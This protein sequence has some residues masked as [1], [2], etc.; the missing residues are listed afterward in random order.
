ML[1]HCRFPFARIYLDRLRGRTTETDI[2]LEIIV[3]A[4]EAFQGDTA[5]VDFYQQTINRIKQQ[6]PYRVALAKQILL[7]LAHARRRLT[8]TELQHVLFAKSL[9]RAISSPDLLDEDELLAMCAGLVTIEQNRNIVQLVHPTLREYLKSRSSDLLP[10]TEQDIARSCLD[11]L[12]LNRFPRRNFTQLQELEEWLASHPFYDYAATNWGHHARESSLPNEGLMNF[13]DD[14]SAVENSITVLMVGGSSR[15][16]T[17]FAD[18]PK[19][20]SVTS[21][22]LATYFQLT[23][24]VL[25]LLRAG[26][27]PDSRDSQGRTPLS[28]TA[29]FGYEAIVSL[30]LEA[31]AE[32]DSKGL[33]EHA[34]TGESSWPP[35]NNGGHA[36]RTPLSF[37]AEYGHVEASK[38]LISHGAD[39]GS[40]CSKHDYRGWTPLL[41]AVYHGHKDVVALLLRCNA[42]LEQP[43]MNDEDFGKTALSH[44][45]EKGH[46]AIVRMLL[47][48]GAS[49][50]P[51]MISTHP[52]TVGHTPLWLAAFGG[53]EAVVELLLEIGGVPLG[54]RDKFG[55][56]IL[57]YMAER[58]HKAMVGFI[59]NYWTVNHQDNN[60]RTPLSYA[61]EAGHPEVVQ[62][63]LDVGADRSLEDEEGE[64]PRSRAIRNR[65]LMV[66]AMLEDASK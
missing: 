61:A 35:S 58:G 56:T 36:G 45:A 14:R 25:E 16:R 65:R 49:T 15:A 44:A 51:A 13:F 23:D 26:L 17:Y 60:G 41:F 62:I 21:L 57:S 39:I 59:S 5:L 46:T 2:L 4:E 43:S 52:D 66:V 48:K 32:T 34:N 3:L 55:R 6:L 37:A 29:G 20:D 7:W 10:S 50:A 9:Q 63:L 31:G 40:E 38:M 1:T 53:H 42:D 33:E 27:D 12:S 11:H 22:H 47:D 30:F 24:L 19:P 8:V 18:P 28:Y 64:T 54:L